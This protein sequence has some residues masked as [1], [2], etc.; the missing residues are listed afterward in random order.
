MC[1][2]GFFFKHTKS[3]YF[4]SSII[5]GGRFK[6]NGETCHDLLAYKRGKEE[7]K[8]NEGDKELDQKFSMVFTKPGVN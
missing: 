7:K 8:E 1:G 3:L 6:A 5:K 4:C 2:G